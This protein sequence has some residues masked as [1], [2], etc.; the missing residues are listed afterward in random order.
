MIAVPGQGWQA[1][2]LYDDR[3]ITSPIIAWVSLGN[4]IF[5]PIASD[6]DGMTTNPLADSNFVTLLRPFEAPPLLSEAREM[7]RAVDRNGGS[8]A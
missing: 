1:C 3:V 8:N 6:A 4:A 5:V 2:L 7:L